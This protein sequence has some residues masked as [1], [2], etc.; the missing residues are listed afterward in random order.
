M[1]RVAVVG[2]GL[3]GLVVA[4]RLARAADVVVFEKSRG[5][6]GRMAT[7]YYGDFE[8]DHGAQFF[9]A[10][11]PEF[12]D[13]LEPMVAGGNVAAWNARF[14][15]ISGAGIT[16][17]RSWDD[18]YPHYVGSPRMNSVGKHLAAGLDVRTNTEV[19]R[20]VHTEAKWLLF[21]GHDAP[22]GRFDWLILTAP[23]EQTLRLAPDVPG[24]AELCRGASMHA[25]FALMLG[26]DSPLD[27]PFDAARVRGR[28]LSWIS[29]N[30]S[31]PGRNAC[32]TLVV[33]S[34]NKWA[35]D[36]FER[37]VGEVRQHL[38]EE[39]AVAAGVDAATASVCEM[40][41]WRY[42]NLDKRQGPTH[43]VDP[44]RRLAACGDWFVR[45]R[46]EAAFRSAAGLADAFAQLL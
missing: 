32:C 37:G 6:G 27:L 22:L 34:T 35:D 3:A 11:S 28:D 17:S 5:V 29:A 43:F 19:S 25:C 38:V 42:A 33:H 7:R 12:R 31:K 44:G 36:N 23:A 30:G 8:F 20:A 1:T 40:H 41:R 14:V 26:F 9:T 13:F 18:A 39:L 10:R 24:L 21:D 45:G 4:G 16:A 46:V 2:A 15:E